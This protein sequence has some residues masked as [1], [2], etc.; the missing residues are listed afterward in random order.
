MSVLP[1]RYSRTLSKL[2]ARAALKKLALP[3]VCK[4]E[5]HFLNCSHHCMSSMSQ[6]W[7]T[8]LN[9]DLVARVMTMHEL[10]RYNKEVWHTFQ[11]LGKA[12]ADTRHRHIFWSEIRERLIFW[13]WK[14]RRQSTIDRWAADGKGREGSLKTLFRLPTIWKKT[15][16]R[17]EQKEGK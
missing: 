2:P 17:P 7:A 4:D 12:W 8:V 13:L 9:S 10:V 15:H 5:E 16:T 11:T 1:F 3:S 14:K 6:R